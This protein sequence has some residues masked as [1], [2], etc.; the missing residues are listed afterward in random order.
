M[1]PV[2]R[3]LLRYGRPHVGVL[4]LAFL[5]SAVVGLAMGGYA[6]LTGPAL[7][8]LLSGGEEGF[9]S[10][11]RVPWLADL[12]REAA[13]W[14]F[15]LLMMVVGAAKGVGYLTQFYFMGMFAQRVSKD[16]RRDLFLR[17]TSLSPAQLARQR[18]GDLLSRFSSDVTAVEAAAM[19]T[20][21]AYIRDTLQ[22]LILTGVALS[23]SPLLGGVMLLVV[24]LAAL[25]ASRLMR[26]V[27]KRTR[28]G[29]TQLGN[30]A[31]QLHE[32]LGGLRTIQAF[33][34]QEAELARFS[35]HAQAHE[36]ALV[37][38]AWARGAVPGL[39]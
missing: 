7:R 24:P 8:F 13:L 36:K 27:L 5:G 17:L 15:P 6:Y 29:Q 39:M 1:W 20:V 16:L 14:G 21:G 28:E 26:K 32:G 37:S 19:Y 38:A 12:P 10:A 25:P 35:A 4:V 18:T 30:L 22:A 34:G 3:R 11:Q 9:A 23:M 31:G 2:L 33:N